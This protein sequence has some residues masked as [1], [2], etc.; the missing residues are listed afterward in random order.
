MKFNKKMN[1]VL[2]RGGFAKAPCYVFKFRLGIGAPLRKFAIHPLLDLGEPM[3]EMILS[4]YR[5]GKKIGSIQ[6]IH[7]R[8][9][10]V[11]ARRALTDQEAAEI[12]L[13]ELVARRGLEVVMEKMEE[14][15]F[16]NE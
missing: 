8:F 2:T 4:D 3:K 5:S 6:P 16:I 14:A 15:T 9:T 1:V 10:L 7:T 11:G 13:T 12:L